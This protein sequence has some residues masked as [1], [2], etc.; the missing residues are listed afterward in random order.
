MSWRRWWP[1]TGRSVQRGYRPI[2]PTR[3]ASREHGPPA[4]GHRRR[5]GTDHRRSGRPHPEWIGAA[6]RQGGLDVHVRATRH[7][8]IGT[9][10]I[11]ATYRVHL[12]HGADPP[13]DAPASVVAKIGVGSAEQRAVTSR[14]FVPEVGFYQQLA[15]RARVRALRVPRTL[16]VQVTRHADTR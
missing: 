8:R 13:P 15:G 2:P 4:V 1:P 6:L 5:L 7:E 16:S 9:G 3:D 14:A 11:A 12:D 10:Q